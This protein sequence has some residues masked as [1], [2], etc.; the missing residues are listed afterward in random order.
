MNIAKTATVQFYA[1]IWTDNFPMI[2]CE[3]RNEQYDPND[4]ETDYD[5]LFDAT[6]DEIFQFLM[7]P[8]VRFY[9]PEYGD[10]LKINAP[11]VWWL[12]TNEKFGI[13]RY[14]EVEIQWTFCQ[15]NPE[16]VRF[17]VQL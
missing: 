16:L 17:Y 15:S 7:M 3:I 11:N 14:N 9:D 12:C 13:V 5:T 6:G 4:K 2:L 1:K 10:D 8:S